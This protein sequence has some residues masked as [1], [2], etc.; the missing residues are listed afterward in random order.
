VT[1]P[2]DE[3]SF[4]FAALGQLDPD[5]RPVFIERVV[6]ILGA[7]PHCEFGPGDFDRAIRAALVGLWVPPAFEEARGTSRWD[8]DRPSFERV[9]KRAQPVEAR[10]RRRPKPGFG[11]VPA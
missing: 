1:L 3:R 9:S 6:A 2:E 11:C 4:F 5:V 7:Y 10:R 8:R